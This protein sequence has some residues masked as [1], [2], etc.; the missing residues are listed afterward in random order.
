VAERRVA[1]ATAGGMRLLHVR[2]VPSRGPAR[3][4][5]AVADRVAAA[6]LLTLLSPVLAVLAV[7]I[8]LDSDGPAVF[9]QTRVGHHGRPFTM[10]KLRTMCQGASR[11]ADDLTEANESDRDGVLFKI[12]RDPRITRVGAFLRRYSLDEVPQ[13]VN[14]VRGEMSLVGPRPALQSEV[15]G[16]SADLR[17]RLVVKPGMTGLWQVSGRS[18]LSWEDTVRL[19]LHYVDNWSWGL[20]AAIAARTAGAVL[21]HRGAY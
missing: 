7:A 10:F 9:R 14:V 13:L 19:D 20:D 21:G 16:Y 2:P 17:H 5:K 12:R 4:L 6:G 11:I 18:D 15:D 1:L 8:R 3:V